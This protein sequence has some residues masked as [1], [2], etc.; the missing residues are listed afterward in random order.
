ME[1]LT[2]V[3][4][5]YWAI[6]F[7]QESKQSNKIQGMVSSKYYADIRSIQGRHSIQDST[8]SSV[9]HKSGN[10]ESGNVQQG[11][12]SAKYIS[13]LKKVKGRVPLH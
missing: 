12:C 7:L 1:N 11:M 3:E 5:N 6:L 2:V 10:R 8:S 9:N 13:D 4:R